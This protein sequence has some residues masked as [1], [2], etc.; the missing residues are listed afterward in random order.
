MASPD[1]NIIFELLQNTHGDFYF[2]IYEKEQVAVALAP[3][4]LH[5]AEQASMQQFSLLK[6]QIDPYQTESQ[7]HLYSELFLALKDKNI[8]RLVN[9]RVRVSNK[10]VLYRFEIPPQPSLVE[11]TLKL[12][13]QALAKLTLDSQNKEWNSLL[14]HPQQRGK[15]SSWYVW[16]R[17][18]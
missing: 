10:V 8:G 1:Q 14:Y 11:F 15:V 16:H 5:F 17:P 4:Q 7:Q 9:F 12:R 6:A 2:Q 13:P 18:N 3:I